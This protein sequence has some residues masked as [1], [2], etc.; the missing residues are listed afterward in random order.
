M[1][2]F[3][4]ILLRIRHGFQSKTFPVETGSVVEL[5]RIRGRSRTPFGRQTSQKTLVSAYSTS[6]F[7][8]S[9]FCLSLLLDRDLF[10][11]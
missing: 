6:L 11:G 7:S 5:R 4:C 10:G 1:A 2:D 9:R 8:K 3:E